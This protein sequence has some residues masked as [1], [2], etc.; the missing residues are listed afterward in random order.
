M[1]DVDVNGRVSGKEV[2]RF[3]TTVAPR[4]VSRHDVTALAQRIMAEADINDSGSLTY[5]EFMKWEGK[6]SVLD[7]IDAYHNRVLSRWGGTEAVVAEVAPLV[8]VPSSTQY[9]WDMIT[10][11]DLARVFNSESW[12]GT[13]VVQEFERVL[14]QFGINPEVG[15]RLF[16]AFD[17]DGN[18]ELDFKE[19]FLGFAVLLSGSNEERLECAFE[20]M[21]A[22]GSGRVSLSEVKHFLTW[23]APRSVSRHDVTALAQRIMAEAD[24]NDSNQ[25]TYKE[26]MKWNGKAAV[27]E[28][29]HQFHNRVLSKWGGAEAVLQEA[30]EKVQVQ[31]EIIYPWDVITPEKMAQVLR[32]ESL[33]PSEGTLVFD[34]FASVLVRLGVNPAQLAQPL[35]QAFDANKN[36][37]ID[38]YEMKIGFALLLSGSREDRVAVAFEMMD[39]NGSGRVSRE[40]MC[41]FVQLVAPLTEARRDHPFSYRA[42]KEN[43]ELDEVA[44]EIMLQADQDESGL[45]T[46]QEFLR[47][48]GRVE[49]MRWI[50]QL[51]NRILYRT[52]F[53]GEK[54]P[55]EEQA[56]QLSPSVRA[57]KQNLRSQRR[58]SIE[59]CACLHN[60]CVT[61]YDDKCQP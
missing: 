58:R 28:W 30:V 43:L 19:M 4:S 36:G 17:Q 26:F 20:M 39:A 29:V 16:H 25:L 18:N 33:E 11:E 47:W 40:E 45:V 10:K 5:R 60:T 42:A 14:T 7:W 46:Y 56:A 32:G 54:P 1:M 15:K 9:P 2:K 13:L 57:A 41:R 34:E 27:V 51:Y 53:G 23:I 12:L 8:T 61:T 52:G 24:T 44:D 48:P 3:L 21:D 37:V 38:L 59:V 50:D 31:R 55:E 6:S 35:F 49:V 22:D